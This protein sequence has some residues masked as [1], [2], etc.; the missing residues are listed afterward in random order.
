MTMGTRIMFMVVIVTT[1]TVTTMTVTTIT[2][3]PG[4]TRMDRSRQNWPAPVAGAADCP[5]S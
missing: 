3:R 5:R 1:I 4:D 2:L